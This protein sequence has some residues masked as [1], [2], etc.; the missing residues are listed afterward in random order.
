ML[1]AKAK[2]GGGEKP[3]TERKKKIYIYIKASCLPWESKKS[4]QA[5]LA[6]SARRRAAT[7]YPAAAF[8]YHSLSLSPG[9][10]TPAAQSPRSFLHTFPPSLQ[11][12]C[13]E[14]AVTE[15][16]VPPQ[17]GRKALHTARS[18]ARENERSGGEFG[19]FF[20]KAWRFDMDLKTERVSLSCFILY[21]KSPPNFKGSGKHPQEVKKQNIFS[22]GD[23]EHLSVVRLRALPTVVRRGRE[24][25]G[26]ALFS[27][28]PSPLA[29]GETRTQAAGPART[30]GF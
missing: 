5:K 3:G 4:T 18:L 24:S 13:P 8:I 6:H 28:P 29:G 14:A 21:R 9:S 7:D 15:G 19:C 20:Q 26:L 16:Q 1:A 22:G 12:L 11:L 27:P 25:Q 30:D 23:D 10:I 2:A 17:S